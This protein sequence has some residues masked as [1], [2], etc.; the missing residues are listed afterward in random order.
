MLE[1]TLDEQSTVDLQ[2]ALQPDALLQYR[3]IGDFQLPVGSN[4]V[5]VFDE[6]GGELLILGEPASGKTITMLQLVK[7]LWEIATQDDDKRLPIVVNLSEWT[8]TKT[9]WFP[10][11]SIDDIQ[12]R[13]ISK[14]MASLTPLKEVQQQ[15]FIEW[16]TAYVA[17]VFDVDEDFIKTQLDAGKLVLVFDGL[18][19]VAPD[20][21][22]AVVTALNEIK[23]IHMENQ[24][25]VCSRIA[26]YEELAEKL[27]LRSAIKLQ[28]LATDVI[29]EQIEANNR[30]QLKAVVTTQ[31]TALT[32]LQSPL[33]LSMAIQTYADGRIDDV[34]GFTLT[35]KTLIHDFIDHAIESLSEQR[36]VGFSHDTIIRYLTFIAY[37]LRNNS[38][39][40]FSRYSVNPGWLPDALQTGIFSDERIEQVSGLKDRSRRFIRNLR[41]KG[42]ALN[43]LASTIATLG[44]GFTKNI[45]QAY[46]PAITMLLLKR[47]NLFP[48]HPVWGPGKFF[49][50]CVDLGLLRSLDNL[51]IRKLV[52]GNAKIYMDMVSP[53]TSNTDEIYEDMGVKFI[54]IHRHLLDYFA[55][56]APEIMPEF[57]EADEDA[58][59]H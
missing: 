16:L 57:Y 32:L 23:A 43:N 19:E 46:V 42:G 52:E 9:V 50:V 38:K 56:L 13:N 18:D 28:P 45:T 37:N 7:G 31:P 36:R 58:S 12:K 4:L 3:E 25:V 21:R 55:D 22:E 34:A 35:Q 20:K 15:T 2:L 53:F 44:I 33:F 8:D 54:F 6:L 26:E 5:T 10:N 24:M 29:I 1:A 48:Y 47:H 49:R 17:N 40:V 39:V 14:I 59:S 51:S 11:L 41:D 30:T 27:D